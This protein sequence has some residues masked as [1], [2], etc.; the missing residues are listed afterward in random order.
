ML[1]T[2]GTISRTAYAQSNPLLPK[3]H[4]IITD[5]TLGLSALPQ[6]YAKPI[7]SHPKG[8]VRARGVRLC[9][10]RQL[11]SHILLDLHPQLHNLAS[12]P[13]KDA[14]SASQHGLVPG[15]A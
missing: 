15:T 2:R 12:P 14:C 13:R 5:K 6:L 10:R 11:T 3:E 1:K 4:L 9:A 7:Q 8:F